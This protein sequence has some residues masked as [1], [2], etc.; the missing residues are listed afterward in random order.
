MNGSNIV[1]TFFGLKTAPE[2]KDKMEV[3]R[4]GVGATKG[5]PAIQLKNSA[6]FWE[7]DSWKVLHEDTISSDV[8]HWCFRNFCYQESKG[9]REVCSRLYQLC[10]QWLKPERNTKAQMLDL[11]VLGQFLVILSPEMES[12]VRECRAETCSQAVDLAEGF[13]LS[14]AEDKELEKKQVKQLLMEVVPAC[15]EGRGDL[16]NPFQD[17]PLRRISQEDPV[18]VTSSWNRRALMEMCEAFICDEAE[19]AGVPQ[20]QGSVS[21][22]E[23]AMY[24]TEEEW[25]LL[26]CG[27]R[28]L[29]REVML[30]ISRNVTALG[31]GEK[32]KKYKEPRVLP[33]EIAKHKVEEGMFEMQEEPKRQERTHAKDRG[34]KFSPFLC[35]EIHGFMT[36]QDHKGK[37]KGKYSECGKTGKNKPDSNKYGRT[38]TKQKQQEY[39]QN[40]ESISRSFPLPLHQRLHMQQKPY[41]ESGK[42]FS[43]SSNLSSYGGF[44]TGGKPYW[45]LVCG[46]SFNQN[47]TLTS[48]KRT[49]TRGKPYKCFECG[50]SFSRSSHLTSHR[51]VHTGEKPYHCVECGKSFSMSS[52]LTSHQRIHTREKP[53]KCF[54]C[55][56]EFSSSSTLVKHKRIHTGEKPYQCMECG[57]SFSRKGNLISHQRIHTGEKPYKCLE[58]GKK[59]SD[60]S[61]L[62]KHKRIHTGEKPFQCTECGKSFRVNSSLTS[63]QRIHTGEKPYKCLE[64][65][66]SFSMNNHLTSHQRIHT[67]EKPYKCVECGKKFNDSSTLAKHKRIHTGEKPYQCFECGRNFRVNC[68][69][70]SH[71]RIHTRIL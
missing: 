58:C 47:S 42:N 22:E 45:C 39:R 21:F 54:E 44:H 38:R 36:Q 8:Q 49:H 40:E 64:C 19:T 23:V 69:L 10:H 12:W 7:R 9:P 25:A 17:P 46:K 16:S 6:V 33:V 5:S 56:K 41:I 1:N 59:F 13:L 57:N 65:G 18:Q 30:E 43:L 3:Q 27:Q 15:P 48:H 66:K 67:G 37:K 60:S 71:R 63:H 14:Q 35:V 70:I 50:K 51:R 24:F 4:S 62:V 2:K 29:Y 34:E 20:A 68:S 28:A 53:Y 26:D 52:H 11:V 31:D 55:G 32:N 61:T